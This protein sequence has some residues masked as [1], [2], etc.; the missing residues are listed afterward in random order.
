[1][2]L[3]LRDTDNGPSQ[4]LVRN[5]QVGGSSPLAGSTTTLPFIKD[6][7]RP[8]LRRDLLHRQIMSPRSDQMSTGSVIDDDYQRALRLMQ[9]SV[10]PGQNSPIQTFW[11]PIPDNRLSG[12]PAVPRTAAR[13][14]DTATP[15]CSVVRWT[16]V[17]RD[18][19]WDGP[20]YGSDEQR[21]GHVSG[22]DQAVART[23]A[24]TRRSFRAWSCPTSALR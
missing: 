22:R 21:E 16:S 4:Q 8:S 9:Q 7:R 18:D 23:A 15:P 13:L 17:V 1:M 2:G 12:G 10:F 5:Q 20:S 6:L 11:S 14:P 24:G 3:F 19:T